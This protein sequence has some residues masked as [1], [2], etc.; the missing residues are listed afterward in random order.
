[1]AGSRTGILDLALRFVDVVLPEPAPHH[2]AHA[3]AHS[4]HAAFFQSLDLAL[5]AL[6]AQGAEVAV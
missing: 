6:A 5:A 4:A 1:M 3:P 2:T